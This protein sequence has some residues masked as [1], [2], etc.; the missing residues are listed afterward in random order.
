MP[1]STPGTAGEIAQALDHLKTELR[2]QLHEQLGA[3]Q[4]WPVPVPSNDQIIL[5]SMPG[6]PPKQR[7]ALLKRARAMVAQCGLARGHA[8]NQAEADLRAL[9]ER[10]A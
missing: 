7:T 3:G 1:S 8:L 6:L 2:H 4:T 9:I 10:S 5:S